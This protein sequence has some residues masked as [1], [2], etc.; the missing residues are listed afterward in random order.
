MAVPVATCFLFGMFWKRTTALASLVVLLVGI[1]LGAL[2]QLWIIP[3]LFSEYSIGRYGLDNFYVVG[4]ITQ[5]CCI[6]IILVLS[7]MTQSPEYDKIKPYIW[8]KSMLRLPKS[9][10][11]RPWWQKVELWWGMIMFI[12]LILYILWW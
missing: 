1:P 12:Y 11:E 3:G 9:D 5:V 10:P 7:L 8:T 4:G 6:V 2:M